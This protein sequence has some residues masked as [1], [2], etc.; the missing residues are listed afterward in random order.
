MALYTVKARMLDQDG[1]L[2]A[3][4][5][6]ET[7]GM[8]PGPRRVGEDRFF[9]IPEVLGM[10][11]DGDAFDLVFTVVGGRVSGGELESDGAGWIREKYPLE[12][13]LIADL[14]TV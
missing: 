9:S 12:G 4:Q 2:V 13:S 1:D 7:S 3:L 8:P 14:P 11:E 5:G 10:I 6:F